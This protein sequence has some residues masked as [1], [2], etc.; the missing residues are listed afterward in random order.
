VDNSIV[1]LIDHQIGLMVSTRDT[2]TV[3]ELRS[4]VLGLARTANVLQLPTLISS[5]NAP[6]QNGDTIPELKELFPDTAIIRRT[7]IINAY[8]DPGLPRRVR[9]HSR[10]DRAPS[11]HHR[12]GHDRHLLHLPDAVASQRRVPR[13]PRHR[14]LRRLEQIRD[15]CRPRPHDTG[16]CGASDD[17]LT[18]PRV[19]GRLEA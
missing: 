10:A 7:G 4:N 3:V 19:A 6:W 15:R 2:S 1:L 18:C 9:R 11:R 17:I 16:R 14:R 8:E 5:S 12:R 13:I